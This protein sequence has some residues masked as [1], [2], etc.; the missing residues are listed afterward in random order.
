MKKT[1]SIV[2]CAVI[3]T[4]ASANDL[5]LNKITVDSTPPLIQHKG[6]LKDL[7]EKTETVDKKELDITHSSTLSEVIEKQ[8]GISVTTGCSICGLKRVQ[9]NGL[10]GEHTT[11]LIDG[12]PFNSTVSSFYGMD[13]IGTSDIES[14]EVARGAGMSLTAPEAIGGIINII[15][16]KPRTIGIEVDLSMGTLGTKNYSILGEAMSTDQKTGVLISASYHDQ[17]QVDNDHNGVS[18]SPSLKNQT[19]SIMLT[20]EFSTIDSVELKVSHFTSNSF[21]GPMVSES[22]AIASYDP[23]N[24]DPLFTN[25]NINN[26]LTSNAMSVLERINTTRD[27]IYLKQH[28]TLNGTMNL[29]TTLAYAEQKQD[30][31]YEGSDYL[32]IDK[33][34]FGDLKIDH[35]LNNNHFLTYGA[36]AKIETARSQSVAFFDVA[37]RDKDDFDYTALGVYAQDAWMIDDKNELTVAVRGAK[38]TTDW[39]AKK[40][41]GNEIDET[42]L[43]PRLLWRH[44]HTNNL[45]SRLSAGMGYRSPLT[46]F[47]SEHGLLDNGFDMAITELEKSKGASY[48]LSY[49]ANRLSITTSAAYTQVKNLAYIDDSAATPVL[50]NSQETVSVKNADITVGYELSEGLNLSG[51]YEIYRYDN[52][53]KSHLSL[54]AI[55]QRA[56]FS[57]D[58]DINGWELYTEATWVG[59]RNLAPYGY[60]NRYNDTL[61]SSPKKTTSPA[62]T[63]IDFRISKALNKNFTLYAGA[64]NLF[65]YTQTDTESPLF[66]DAGGGFDSAHIWGPLRGRMAYTGL[67]ASF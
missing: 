16:R 26:P 58:Y 42:M 38:I 32:N 63:T 20:H 25:G 21:G 65:D 31:L 12:I 39:R 9:M 7:V 24:N 46:F 45:T 52:A 29:Q 1:L 37:G 43:I 56:R 50:R 8:T 62:F 6:S 22:S 27:E 17:N 54:A 47:E 57:V 61:A 23:A 5:Q 59:E 13:A 3:C 64:K 66:F 19:L 11:V 14:I 60:D 40:A 51:A 36:D 10:K 18:E 44:N 41:Q 48:A 2:A 4:F 28:H 67:Q 53:Y 15:P 33:T 55:E 34:Y 49:D 35:A 30:S